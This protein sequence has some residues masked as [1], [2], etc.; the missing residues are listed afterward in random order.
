M[1]PDGGF[2]AA[3]EAVLSRVSALVCGA[4]ALAIYLVLDSVPADWRWLARAL[5]LVFAFIA[6][7]KL[8][9]GSA[10]ELRS[11]LRRRATEERLKRRK[12]E[13]KAEAEAENG[14]RKKAALE[15]AEQN[16]EKEAERS[17]IVLE[18]LDHLSPEE[19]G[20]ISLALE[21]RSQTIFAWVDS[22]PGRSLR[23]KGIVQSERSS[24]HEDYWPWVF[25]DFV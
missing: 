11:Y 23:M 2:F 8:L 21:Q 12:A 24:G 18:R 20:F 10:R 17:R 13:A 22:H 3:I 7:A 19:I 25:P 16:R 14:R 5:L 6:A 1:L 15:E 4:V 9:D